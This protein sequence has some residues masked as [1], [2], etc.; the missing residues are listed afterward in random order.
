M[1]CWEE[2]LQVAVQLWVQAVVVSVEVRYLHRQAGV[3][4]ST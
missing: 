2:L 3:A 4:K 1:P